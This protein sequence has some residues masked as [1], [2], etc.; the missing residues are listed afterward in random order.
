MTLKYLPFVLEDSLKLCVA[1]L[2]FLA[3]GFEKGQLD[4]T[5]SVRGM[6]SMEA[7][8]LNADLTQ[9]LNALSWHFS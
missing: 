3:R 9:F 2:A 5:S 8:D 4:S 6:R 7:T 1:Q